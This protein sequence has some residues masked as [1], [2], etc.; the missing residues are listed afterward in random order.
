MSGRVYR[1]IQ[2][3]LRLYIKRVKLSLF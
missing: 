2:L 3:Y 1:V